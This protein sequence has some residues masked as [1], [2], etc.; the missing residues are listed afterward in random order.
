MICKSW[1]VITCLFTKPKLMV[2]FPRRYNPS[3]MAGLLVTPIHGADLLNLLNFWRNIDRQTLILWIS[4]C[5]LSFCYTFIMVGWFVAVRFHFRQICRL[6]MGPWYFT[7]PVQCIC[8]IFIMFCRYDAW[9]ISCVNLAC[10]NTNI[11]YAHPL[12]ST[13]DML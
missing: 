4:D 2:L 12:H 13:I 7:R 6:S 3:T 11:F 8:P 10:H 5:A 1:R 9:L